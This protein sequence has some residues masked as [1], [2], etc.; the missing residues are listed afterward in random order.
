M[1]KLKPKTQH[2]VSN[3]QHPA[4]RKRLI[5]LVLAATFIITIVGGCASTVEQHPGAV[6]SGAIGAI[7]GAVLGGIIGHQVD[8]KEEGIIIGAIL[9]GLAGAT[10][11]HYAYDVKRDR[12]QTVQRYSYTPSSGNVVRIEDAWATPSP[13]KPGDRVDLQ[14]TY[15]ILNPD[16][17]AQIGIV[18]TRE[19]RR[20]GVLVGR[21]EV[22]VVRQGGTY[23]STIPLFL[24]VNAA[25]GTYVVVTTVD[26]GIAK[27]T[28][29][30]TF[31]VK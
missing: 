10:I 14:A 15:A 2:Q 13:V 9:G 6:S 29:E 31:I 4:S 17:N 3:I 27:D 16:P 23:T 20:N 18:E 8:R 26:S 28:R 25:P 30:T 19:I 24:P 1:E 12:A 22:K 5:S 11:G 21:P 7:G